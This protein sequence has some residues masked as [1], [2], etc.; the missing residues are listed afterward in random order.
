MT[1][2]PDP[3]PFL[4]AAEAVARR[5][6]ELLRVAYRQPRRIDYK[7][8]VN[9]VTQADRES[10]ALIIRALRNQFPGTAVLAEE[11]GTHMASG[12]LIW[13]VDPLDGTNNFA[14][15][16]PM[17][18]VSIALW[19][20]EGP[21][22]GV[23]Y[24]PLRDE[25]FCAARGRGATLNGRPI[26][27]SDNQPLRR[28]LISTGFPYERSVAADNNTAA[29]SAFLHRALDV[30]SNGSVALDLAFVAC[31]RLDGY[32]ERGPEPW[33]VGAG[34]LLVTEAGGMVSRYCGETRLTAMLQGRDYV[35]SNGLIHAEMLAVL[36]EVYDLGE[37][38]NFKL[39]D[40][41]A[42]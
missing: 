37:D 36:R 23:V 4:D 25:C 15:G 5:A 22:V 21:L 24:D 8:A 31:G 38:G 42:T 11:S 12:D 33:D 29:I 18:C 10:E 13:L 39:K 19:D 30:R 26:H 32:W 40:A 6:G 2:H 14:H 28:G 17:F 7:G 3:Q 35:A 41:Q 27:V 9:L 16:F 20:A 1:A 34:L